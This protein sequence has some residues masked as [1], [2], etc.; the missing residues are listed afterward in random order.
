MRSF[1]I[2]LLFAALLGS[3]RGWSESL[4]VVFEGSGLSYLAEERTLSLDELRQLP[5]EAMKETQS[6]RPSLGFS[7]R[8]HWFQALV[9]NTSDR[10]SSIIFEIAYPRLEFVEFYA[11][12]ASAKIL[13][14]YTAGTEL[15]QKVRPINHM[16][17]AFPVTV[18]AGARLHFYIKVSTHS[19]LRFPVKIWEP[20]EFREA[21]QNALMLHGLYFGGIGIMVFYNMFV[22]LSTRSL[23]YLFYS[24]FV[25][26]AGV[27]VGS[28]GGVLLRYIFTDSA[29]W[30]NKITLL[31]IVGA[32]ISGLLFVDYFM[33]LH[34]TD[35]R[36]HRL[37]RIII[38]PLF[39]S[40]ALVFLLSYSVV[41]ISY[42]VISAC[43]SIL[44]ITTTVRSILRK[45][46][47]AYFYA[48]AWISLLLGIIFFA[49][50]SLGFI[51]SS[52]IAEKSVQIGS[53]FEVT[54]LCALA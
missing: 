44:L 43:T 17:F 50:M 4:P 6:L 32:N 29:F 53:L 13:A 2:F 42:T 18:P 22:F 38:L 34:K 1:A 25:I 31:S 54:I 7:S 9:R 11:L 40:F 15:P 46:R 39:L 48:A 28:E 45:Q 27:Y 37:M 10:D 5:K 52:F 30:N 24:L 47:E 20:E 49:L 41:G 35:P 3:D 16:N 8:P 12:D 36:I 19:P 51:P 26:C 33:N 23:S 14:Q 21:Q